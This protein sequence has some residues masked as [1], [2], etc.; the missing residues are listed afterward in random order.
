ML[1]VFLSLTVYLWMFVPASECIIVH[2]WCICTYLELCF[3]LFFFDCLCL[4]LYCHGLY[5][6][7]HISYS[8]FLSISLYLSFSVSVCI[9]GNLHVC[10]Q[11]R[12][13]RSVSNCA[14][15]N[16]CVIIIIPASVCRLVIRT[17]VSSLWL[18]ISVPES[19][20]VMTH[21]MCISVS[22]PFFFSSFFSFFLC[23]WIYLVVFG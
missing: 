19:G 13:A 7:R 17:S 2:S 9:I 5:L 4:W 3:S 16:W 6:Y 22:W 8:A 12:S 20:Y 1:L 23:T 10:E 15:E 11:A 14:L 21:C 18:W